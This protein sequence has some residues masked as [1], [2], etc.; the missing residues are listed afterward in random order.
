MRKLL[1]WFWKYSTYRH[2]MLCLEGLH[3]ALEEHG[4]VIFSRR[5]EDGCVRVDV[6]VGGEDIGDGEDVYCALLDVWGNR[7]FRDD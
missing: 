6:I 7:I 1:N 5:E 4:E 2:Y 3:E